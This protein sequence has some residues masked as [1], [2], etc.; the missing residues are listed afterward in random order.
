MNKEEII[1][2]ISAL[3]ED[4]RAMVDNAEVQTRS[5]NDEE[6][7]SFEEKK[8]ELEKLKEQLAAADKE[9][10]RALEA[11]APKQDKNKANK[12]NM[13]KSYLKNLAKQISDVVNNRSLEGY[14]NV[15]GN[16]INLR[17]DA[18]TTKTAGDVED[19]QNLEY[20]RVIEPLEDAVI[21]QKLGMTFM[22]T[23]SL[24]KLP[25]VSNVDCT[26][27]GE[28]T[29]LDTQKI[30]YDAKSITPVRLG[31]AV[32]LSNTA[33]KTIDNNVNLVAYALKAMREAE[34][35]L[36]NKMVVSPVAV[37]NNGVNVKGPF[38][39]L[40]AGD[41]SV[42]GKANWANIVALE[43]AVKNKNAE[44]VDGACFIM[45]P[46][47]ADKLR[48]KPIAVKAPYGDRFIMEDGKI[49]GF[50]VYQTNAVNALDASGNVTYSYIGFIADPKTIIVQEVGAPD[51]V[52]DP[53]TRAKWNETELVLNDNLGFNCE[54]DEVFAAMKIDSSSWT[55]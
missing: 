24:V 6:K 30:A 25:S 35:R 43:T 17:D 36:I 53:F 33:V 54:R 27:N 12:R 50:P 11:A 47:T 40:L 4:L 31:C 49:D 15:S 14:D 10:Q 19:Y 21:F 3:K 38:V 9:E 52:V 5:L 29:K 28:N 51:L 18:Y 37:T 8:A 26:I 2:K 55:A 32:G 42:A 20:T 45:S 16:T 13:E 23:G 41:A 48:T 7:N 46:D 44:I 39:D 1:E 34:G 22:N